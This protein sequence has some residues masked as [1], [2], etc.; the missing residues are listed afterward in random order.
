MS[1]RD[2]PNAAPE[3]AERTEPDV[4]APSESEPPAPIRWL[5]RLQQRVAPAG[6][7]F[8]VVKK[9][10][11]DRG[12]QFAALLS[13]YGFFSLFPLLLVA[14]SILGFV[15]DGNP[16]LQE[17]IIDSAISRFPVVGDQIAANVG[18]VRGSRIAVVVGL[19]VALWAGLGATQAAQDA[20]NQVFAVPVLERKNF[21]IRRLRGLL[22]LV[23]FGLAVLG[24]T[25]VGSAGAWLGLGGAANRAAWLVVAL[26][27]NAAL[28]AA[29]FWVLAHQRLERSLL[30]PGVVVGA[31]GFTVLQ[32]VGT[33]YVARVVQGASRTY[34]VFAAVIGLLSWIYLQATIFLYAAEVSTVWHGRLWPRSIIRERP[35]DADIRVAAL[36]AAREER[37]GPAER[38][39]AGYRQCDPG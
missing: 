35:T 3:I 9:F 27:L 20:I 19:V 10:G 13:Y 25:L 11:D 4:G 1:E 18:E 23:V 24:T 28:V 2:L 30:V 12:G 16:D 21:W 14:V 5:N 17:R 33:Q 36:I 26:L 32:V 29:L 7:V 39:G 15:I 34:G 31:V 38:A 8:A 37:L 6:F 22:T